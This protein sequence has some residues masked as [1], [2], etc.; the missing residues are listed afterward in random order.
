MVFTDTTLKAPKL[1]LLP[2]LHSKSHRKNLVTFDL[3]GEDNV[4]DQQ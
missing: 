3:I 4:K 1:L 2:A